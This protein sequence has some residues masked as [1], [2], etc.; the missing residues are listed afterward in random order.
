M[1][2]NFDSQGNNCSIVFHHLPF[3]AW[4]KDCLIDELQSRSRPASDDDGSPDFTDEDFE[5]FVATC[6]ESAPTTEER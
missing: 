1:C 5:A 4:C 6:P 2:S 3:S